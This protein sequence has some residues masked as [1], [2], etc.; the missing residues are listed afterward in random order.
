MPISFIGINVPS[1]LYSIN[2]VRY[3]SHHSL[4]GSWPS[5][6]IKVK[7]ITFIYLYDTL[8]S[9]AEDELDDSVDLVNV[10][11]EDAITHHK[12]NTEL[13]PVAYINNALYLSTV[14]DIEA[15][16]GSA[17]NE[18]RLYRIVIDKNGNY[19]ESSFSLVFS[20]LAIP[21][22]IT[23]SNVM[24]LN[25]A[26]G[27]DIIYRSLNTSTGEINDLLDAEYNIRADLPNGY[28]TAEEAEKIALEESKNSKYYNDSAKYSFTPASE[29]ASETGKEGTTL[30]KNIDFSSNYVQ[31][32]RSFNYYSAIKN[33]IKSYQYEKSPEYCWEVVLDAEPL[34]DGAPYP[35][36]IVYVNAKT[37]EVSFV[38][39]I[40]DLEKYNNDIAIAT[41]T[42]VGPYLASSK[43]I[44]PICDCQF[45]L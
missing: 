32:G 10:L 39:V 45:S 3:L 9:Y 35:E 16:N 30:W 44:N 38:T 14:E 29:K 20:G 17:I 34:T 36:V 21:S 11:K 12:T 43:S 28:I 40:P 33:D 6:N 42:T 13:E 8:K 2:S 4:S 23:E 24:I 19:D 22:F 26:E 31:W 37:R 7:S 27:Q 25:C 15:D 1:L 18:Q 41:S 5:P